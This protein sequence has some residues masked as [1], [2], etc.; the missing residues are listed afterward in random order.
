[1]PHDSHNSPAAVISRSA[2]QRSGSQCIAQVC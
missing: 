1:V 2:D